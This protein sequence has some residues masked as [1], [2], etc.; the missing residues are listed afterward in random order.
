MILSCLQ[1][2][3]MDKKI[4]GIPYAF[5]SNVPPKKRIKPLFSIGQ[6]HG[7]I[8]KKSDTGK[9]FEFIYNNFSNNGNI[10]TSIVRDS[11]FDNICI[12]NRGTFS[13]SGGKIDYF[14][15]LLDT[16]TYPNL[17]LA[18]GGNKLSNRN[19]GPGEQPP[20][21]LDCLRNIRELNEGI[22]ALQ[23]SPRVIVCTVLKRLNCGNY[24]RALMQCS[25]IQICHISNYIKKPLSTKASCW[26]V[27]IWTKRKTWAGKFHE[28]IA[29]WE[30]ASLKFKF[31]DL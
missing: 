14:F 22:K 31:A 3:F 26:T 9:P 6:E 27:F 10:H 19:G 8:I 28:Q 23:H 25:Q 17:V 11:I 1:F 20:D 18:V 15:F 4:I 30:G 21:V 16:P 2:S 5:V 13:L 12:D 7:R 24:N 29:D